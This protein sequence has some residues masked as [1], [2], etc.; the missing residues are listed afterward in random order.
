MIIQKKLKNVSFSYNSEAR[1]LEIDINGT[2]DFVRVSRVEMFSLMRFIIRIA[3][4]GKPRSPQTKL[5]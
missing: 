4:K 3:Q 2:S 5:L 1:L